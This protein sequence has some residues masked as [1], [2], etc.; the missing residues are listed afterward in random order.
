MDMVNT[1]A[2]TERMQGRWLGLAA[3]SLSGLVLGL[4]IT[5]LV[6]ALPTLS[7]K[8]G[9]T[10]DQLQWMS[11]A[12]TLSLAG[13]M[14]PAGVLGDRFGRR[15]LLLI[16]LVAFGISSVAAS[17]VTTANGLIAMRAVM[18]VSGAVSWIIERPRHQVGG[19]A[20]VPPTTRCRTRPPLRTRRPWRRSN[21]AEPRRSWR[22]GPPMT[23]TCSS[24]S[25]MACPPG[26]FSKH[27]SDHRSIASLR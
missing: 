24:P 14:L 23:A 20:R 11:A 1:E 16:A 17:Q 22:P 13:F 6:T 26:S 7:A 21:W 15:R 9:A 10:T 8:L 18:G 19:R 27:S 25:S 4:D 5:V 12:Y 3:L 2:R